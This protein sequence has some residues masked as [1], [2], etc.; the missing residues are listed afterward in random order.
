M[1]PLTT[2]RYLSSLT[3]S[4]GGAERNVN[5]LATSDTDFSHYPKIEHSYET[6]RNLKCHKAKK[7]LP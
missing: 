4:K 2:P 1:Q 6:F 7:P 5:Y 3:H